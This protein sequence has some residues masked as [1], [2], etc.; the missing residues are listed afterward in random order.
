MNFRIEKVGIIGAGTMGGGIAAHLANVGIDVLLLDMVTPNLNR[1]EKNDPSVRNRL[2][3][4]LYD[5][6]V[7][8]R[9]A[10]LARKDRAKFISTG[11][12]ED[13]FDRLAECDW[14]I[15]VIVEQLAPKQALMK[16]LEGIRKP[17]SIISSN[18]SGIPIRNICEILSEEFRAKFLGT[19]F[20]NPPRY[21]KLLE[22]IPTD[23]TDRNVLNFMVSFGR[24]VLGK[25]V[26]VCKD[27]PNF[28][29]NR[30]FAIG[31]SF[32][33]EYAFQNGYS[34]AEIDA[35]TGP[36]V[37]RP[38]TAT[39]RLMDLIGLDVMS[40][41]NN[42]LYE[43]VPSDPYREVLRSQ[44]TSVVI[45]QMLENNWLGNK[46]GQGFYK[47]SFVNGKREFWALN[48]AT[49]EYE[50]PDKVRFASVGNV[51]KLEE[52]PDRLAALLD[53][54]D[55]KA[56]R[57]V[58]ET[59]YHTL[60]YAAYVAPEI[61]Y[62]LTDVDDAVRWGFAYEAGPF[63]IWDMLGVQ[64]TV[65]Q[66]EAAGFEVSNWV[67]EMLAAG[68]D[69]F[70][71]NG[72]YY[73]F[74]AKGY[75]PKP[76]DSKKISI[77]ILRDT[78][79]E[80]KLNMSA[81]LLDMGDGVALLEMHSP[82]I[83]SL[84]PDFM[85]MAQ[86]ALEYLETDFD[87][88]VIGNTGQDFCIGANIALIA[89]AASQGLWDQVEDMIVKGQRV[90]FD[91]R[92]APKPVVTAPHQRVLGGGVEL[93]IASWAT[94]ADHETYM[95]QVEVGVGLIPASGGC[96]ELLRRKVNPVM[97]TPNADV[98]P[99]MQEVFE[100]LATAKV[101]GSAWEDIELGFLRPEDVVVMN[102]D[103]RLARAKRKALELVQMGAKPPEVE[104]IYA[105]GRD[106][107]SALNLGIQTYVWAGY[108]S[109]FDAKISRKLAYILC[110]GDLS[111]PAWVDPWYILDL[112][113]E[114]FLSLVGEPLTQERIMHMLQT[115]K[116]L[117]N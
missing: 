38:K 13:D 61:A 66:I 76:D 48:P 3:N 108:A 92:H 57:F 10:N 85:E 96:K 28:I 2:V 17:A 32:D 4:G 62:R 40:H 5:R 36:L 27:T 106:V 58:R 100:V 103:H 20:F 109:D 93:T 64:E 56:V 31:A 15:E 74:A 23:D 47:K 82:K 114:A 98:V 43:A 33:I 39:F 14:I 9:P 73:D 41:V 84:D 117:R 79:R 80:V 75:L 49:M 87:A 115:G 67:K 70:Y 26:V 65:V 42:N 105:A 11:N 52:L 12:I 19:H 102:T 99:V 16:R 30:F 37:G 46:S 55:D 95:G 18:T 101:G 83:N 107:L 25:G 21:L 35:L 78:G 94:V 86:F 110:G 111:G 89:I 29:A 44:K 116:A 81:S 59:L 1:E 22:V 34:V 53:Q 69:T 88:L 77:E 71:H 91:L 90:F 7:K 63:E 8:S 68:Y 112:E 45:G 54:E 72:S 6:M 104:P 24:D 60:A 113:R 97:R 51:R 50:A